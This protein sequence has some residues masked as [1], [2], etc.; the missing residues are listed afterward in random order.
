[1]KKK[2][3]LLSRLKSTSKSSSVR[4]CPAQA[5]MYETLF[6][7]FDLKEEIKTIVEEKSFNLVERLAS[8]IMDLVL[9]HKQACSVQVSVKKPQAWK[10]SGYPSVT[11]RKVKGI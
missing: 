10:G 2:E 4:T 1:M 7:W 3:R 11:L 8:E 5:T 6:H 9:A